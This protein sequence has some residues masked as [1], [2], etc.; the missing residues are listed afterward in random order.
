[1]KLDGAQFEEKLFTLNLGWIARQLILKAEN[2]IS[3]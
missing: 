1:M 2:F 3:G